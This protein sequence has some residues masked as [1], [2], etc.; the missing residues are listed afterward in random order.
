MMGVGEDMVLAAAASTG[1]GTTT[2]GGVGGFTVSGFGL[3]PT[4]E[5]DELMELDPS[6]THI[7]TQYG[8]HQQH[9]GGGGR[10]GSE[11]SLSPGESFDGSEM[12]TTTSIQQE[13][14]GRTRDVIVGRRN[15]N[16]NGNGIGGGGGGENGGLGLSSLVA[17]ES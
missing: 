5:D 1:D 12:M 13:E 14:R 3:P 7:N 8:Q 15:A 2:G 16:V 11:E 10:G 9:Q 17:M 4:N 6:S